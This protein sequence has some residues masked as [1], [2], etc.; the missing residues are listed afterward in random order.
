MDRLI[1]IVN[2]AMHRKMAVLGF[3]VATAYWPTLLSSAFVPRWGAIAI[4]VPLV[5]R[6]DPREVPGSIKC[7]L[8]FVLGLAAIS[9]TWASPNPMSGYLD[10]FYIVFLCLAFVAATGLDSLDDVMTGLGLGLAVSAYFSL[11]QLSGASDQ[12]RDGMMG[13]A[14]TALFYSSEVFA[15]FAAI[16]FVWALLRPRP[17]LAIAAALPIMLCNSRIALV[18]AGAAML[19][20][21]RPNSKVLT[22]ILSVGLA[23]AAVAMIYAFGEG[24]LGSAGQRIILWGATILAWTQFGHGLGWFQTVHQSEQ[25]AHSDAIQAVAEI[26]VGAF[27][28]L[29]IPFIALQRNR[30]N[31]AERA[32]FIAICFEVFVS[33]PLHFPATGFAAAMLAGFLVSNRRLVPLGK[34]VGRVRDGL[35]IQRADAANRGAFSSGGSRGRQISVR[36]ALAWGQNLRTREDSHDPALCRA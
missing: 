29:M 34:P 33:F 23:V 2:W 26:G 9:T 15:E 8:L 36:S 5:S 19:Y 17:M 18:I 3:V 31:N 27:A 32:A 24:K 10:L 16:I 11:F 6:I 13:Q 1:S 25:F 4:G 7:L 20:A 28:L 12:G 30:G 22:T 35:G 21:F 14:P